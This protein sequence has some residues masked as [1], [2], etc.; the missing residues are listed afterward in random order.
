[1]ALITIQI[2]SVVGGG[3]CVAASDGNKVHDEILAAFKA[4]HRVEL[5]FQNVTRMT[6][7][8]LNAAVGQLYGEFSEDQLRAMLAPPAHAEPWHLKRLKLV[9][10]R[11]KTYFRDP[12]AATKAFREVTGLGDEQ[13]D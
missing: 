4:H 7:A 6:T 5:S 1:M 9:V 10:D 3:I 13:D 12:K 2:A 8:F 11:A